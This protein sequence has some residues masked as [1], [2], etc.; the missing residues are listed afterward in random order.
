MSFEN[1]Q[2][3]PTSAA[4]FGGWIVE[5]ASGLPVVGPTIQETFVPGVLV[6]RLL[7]QDL[8]G[9]LRLN[10]AELM[11]LSHCRDEAGHEEAQLRERAGAATRALAVTHS[12]DP[13]HQM[14]VIDALSGFIPTPS[15]V[16]N[17]I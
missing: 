8:E 16:R 10:A 4:K 7:Q 13:G 9:K 15:A 1:P 2:V 6:K 11:A 5:R 3:V 12:T 17:L 14:Q